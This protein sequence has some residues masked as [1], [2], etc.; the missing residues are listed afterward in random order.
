MGAEGA[1]KILYRGDTAEETAKHE[2]EY[3]DKFA[4]PFV[5]ASRGFIDEVIRPQNTRWRI[6]RGLALLKNKQVQV[7]YKKHDNL[8]L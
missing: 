5:A 6:C 1:S 7:P 4:N 3:R 2:E 8:P